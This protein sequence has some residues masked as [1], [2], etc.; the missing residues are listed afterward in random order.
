MNDLVC[1][2]SC[3]TRRDANVFLPWYGLRSGAEM[4]KPLAISLTG[5]SALSVVFS[6]TA[7]ILAG[8]M[9]LIRVRKMTI[10]GADARMRKGREQELTA[11]QE[12]FPHR[13][14]SRWEMRA[15]ARSSLTW[16]RRSDRYH[17]TGPW[18]LPTPLSL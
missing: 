14:L 4:Q 18:H 6:L 16:R 2:D 12:K 11:K 1:A 3:S 15:E 13:D 9:F 8:A 17:L 10:V 7:L 5:A